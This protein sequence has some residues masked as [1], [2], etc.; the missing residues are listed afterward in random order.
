MMRNV[1][2]TKDNPTEKQFCSDFFI[3]G[4]K[5]SPAQ[6]RVF[7][8]CGAAFYLEGSNAKTSQRK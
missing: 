3:A 4:R 6:K 2:Q 1:K 7:S 8:A 5:C